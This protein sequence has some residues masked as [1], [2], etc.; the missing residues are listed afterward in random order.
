MV[1]GRPGRI[2]DRH[3]VR[4]VDEP[5]RLRRGRRRRGGIPP[6][7]FSFGHALGFEHEH[8]NPFSKCENEFNWPRIY[9]YLEGPPNNWT[10]EII[11]HN[12]RSLHESGLIADAFDLDS[13]MLYTFPADYLEPRASEL[14]LRILQYRAICGRST[15]GGAHV[16]GRQARG[17]QAVSSR[18]RD[19]PE[20]SESRRRGPRDEGARY[21][22][23]KPVSAKRALVGGGCRRR[24]HLPTKCAHRGAL[25]LVA[26]WG[27]SCAMSTGASAASCIS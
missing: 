19:A 16:P 10:K 12:M 5:K 27:L 13:I 23:L 6:R 22:K 14:V 20:E 2:S 7:C 3:P 25:D 1:A 8:Q 4:K 18:P 24:H 17:G 9:Q 26:A 21:G 15:P 11:D